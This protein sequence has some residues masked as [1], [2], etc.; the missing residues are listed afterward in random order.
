[1]RRI[2][3]RPVQWGVAAVTLGGI[4]WLA[5]DASHWP[6][7]DQRAPDTL[8]AI[9]KPSIWD[10]LLADRVTVGFVR[11]GIVALAAFVIVSV[12]ALLVAGRWLKALGTGGLTAD[13]ATETSSR[14]DVLEEKL[15]RATEK[16]DEVTKERDEARKLV[17]SLLTVRS[18]RRVT[19]RPRGGGSDTG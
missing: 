9:A 13:E 7:D 17:R 3:L 2:R 15:D 11:L 8:D 6:F 1:M 10:Y 18:K 5:V 19:R 12:P 16:V 4:T 14:I